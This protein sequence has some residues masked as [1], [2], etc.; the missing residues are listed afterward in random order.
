MLSFVVLSVA[1]KWNPFISR[2]FLPVFVL[3]APFVGLLFDEKKLRPFANSCAVVLLVSSFF[4]LANNQMRP[5]VGPKSVFTTD[6]L[7]QYFMVAPQAKQYFIATA[8]MIKGQP[9]TNIGILDRDSNMWEYLLW[10]LLQGDGVTYRIEHVNVQNRSNIIKL[11][12]FSTY[13][14]VR[15]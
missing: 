3:S 6:R 11:N 9:I 15:I 4:V 10:V 12:N 5:L 8:N 13:F 14:P 2:Y 7:N 1:I